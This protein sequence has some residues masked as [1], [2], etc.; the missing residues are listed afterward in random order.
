MTMP[1][2]FDISDADSSAIMHPSYM[3]VN[4]DSKDVTLVLMKW[5]ST[6]WGK[7]VAQ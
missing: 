7:D 4:S 5:S 2:E 3:S 1:Y 6:T